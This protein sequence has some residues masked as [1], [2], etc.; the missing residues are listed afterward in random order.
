MVAKKGV[1]KVAPK[2]RLSALIMA[3]MMAAHLAARMVSMKAAKLVFLKVVSMADRMAVTL[4]LRSA[5]LKDYQKAEMWVLLLVAMKADGKAD[6]MDNMSAYSLAKTMVDS[7]D[8][9]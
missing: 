7:M 2:A 4:V 9:M 8:S 5:E 3:G 1:W 6:L